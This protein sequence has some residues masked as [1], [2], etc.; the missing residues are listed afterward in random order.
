MNTCRNLT[1]KELENMK[2]FKC[3]VTHSYT[4]FMEK[5]KNIFDNFKITEENCKNRLL[6]HLNT[7]A[8]YDILEYR[9]KI[10]G[11]IV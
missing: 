3:G 6:E 10:T 11:V 2:N 8:A 9:R 4:M 5:R 7:K 1:D